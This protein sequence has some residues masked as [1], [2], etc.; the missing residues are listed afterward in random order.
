[1]IF[2]SFRKLLACS[3]LKN[4]HIKQKFGKT[5]EKLC[6]TCH[7][8]IFQLIPSTYTKISFRVPSRSLMCTRTST[9]VESQTK[10]KQ[11][12]HFFL[13]WLLCSL[14]LRHPQCA[15]KNLKRRNY[16]MSLRKAGTIIYLKVRHPNY[17][18]PQQR[19]VSLPRLF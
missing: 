12:N 9:F 3:T 10:P 2:Q 5:E 19:I 17:K 13:P 8:L 7:K 15:K 11:F 6:S 18:F 16:Y 4:H 14:P 1:M